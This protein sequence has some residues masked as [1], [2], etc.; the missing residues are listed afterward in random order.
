MSELELSNW[1][2]KKDFISYRSVY[3]KA[4][5]EWDSVSS[6]EERI[7]FMKEYDDVLFIRDSIIYPRID[8]VLYQSLTNRQ[9]IYETEGIVNK[10]EGDYIISVEKKDVNKLMHSRDLIDGL[11]A[12]LE[13]NVE[14]IRYFK[15]LFSNNQSIS[16]R[17]NAACS[18][19]ITA[20]YFYN[21]SNCRDDREVYISARSFF[22][23]TTSVFGD[24]R[25]PRVEFKVW[26]KLRTGTFCRWKDYETTLAYQNITFSIMAWE[27]LNLIPLPKL[28]SYSLPDYAPTNDRLDL[29]W[30]QPIGS[31]VINL[32]IVAQPFLS[33][34]AE[35]SS[36]G[37]DNNWAVLDCQ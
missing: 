24:K 25:Q 3:R 20:S 18:A 28:Y 30:N 37:V 12:G 29:T 15:F 14:G 16:S 8:V 22:T 9:G 21:Q 32:S 26:G 5:Q 35:G 1:E 17:I 4:V 23:L 2:V 27:V 7:L 11:S 33:L 6:K 34:H 36:R 19:E 10:I 31:Q 13:A